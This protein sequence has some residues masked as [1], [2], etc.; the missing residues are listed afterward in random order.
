MARENEVFQTGVGGT[1][2]HTI[3]PAGYDILVNGTSKYVNFNT[4]V[5][6]SGYGFRDNAGSMEVKNSGGVWEGF[7]VGGGGFTG[8]LTDST[9]TIIA[10]VVNGLI[11]TVVSKS[12]LLWETGSYLT[13]DSSGDKILL[14]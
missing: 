9:S 14:V 3:A 8:N 10:T 6:S 5:G 4:V 13:I 7:G 11:I 2:I 12:Y 1:Y